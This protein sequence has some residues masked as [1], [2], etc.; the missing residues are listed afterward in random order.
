MKDLDTDVLYRGSV[1]SIV[2]PIEVQAPLEERSVRAVAFR[3]SDRYSVF[4]WGEMPDSIPYKGEVLAGW[5]AYFFEIL[6]D[7]E[8]WKAFSRTP[9]ALALRKGASVF[10]TENAAGEAVPRSKQG[11]SFSARFN[12]RGEALQQEGLY[13]HAIGLCEEARL[14]AGWETSW[15]AQDIKLFSMSAH[16]TRSWLVRYAPAI[17][18]ERGRVMGREVSDYHRT[19][20]APAP[21]MIPLEVVFR[22]DVPPGSSLRARIDRGES[23]LGLKPQIEGQG[24]DPAQW[25][26]GFPLIE[27]YTKLEP[28]DRRLSFSEALAISGASTE[29]LDEVICRTAWVAGF[30]K[31]ALESVGIHLSDGKLEWAVDEEGEVMLADAIGPDELRISKEGVPLSKEFLRQLYRD[32]PWGKDL[33]RAKKEA[34]A[35]GSLDWKK[36]VRV[37]GPEP[38][39]EKR[40]RVVSQ[41]YASVFETLT[42]G[43]GWFPECGPLDRVLL[44]MQALQKGAQSS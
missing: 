8:R 26:F 5:S 36:R 2:G 30:L 43:K 25:R 33:E 14:K 31:D 27:F 28:V 19:R 13:T 17:P 37:P 34:E 24:S 10:G 44:E 11:P 20:M 22:F 23:I 21:K 41:M 29:Q 32:T 15:G 6:S 18:P 3:F 38:L 40:V 35:H 12:E 39:G 4:D 42:R 16:P 9:V 1:K 7:P